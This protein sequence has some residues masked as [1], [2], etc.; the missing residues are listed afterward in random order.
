MAVLYFRFA[1]NVAW[2]AV[3]NLDARTLQQWFWEVVYALEYHGFTTLAFVCDG[4]G[5]N[6]RFQNLCIGPK[7]AQ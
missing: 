3:S 6:R 5:T 1:L 2:Y 7:R 4:A